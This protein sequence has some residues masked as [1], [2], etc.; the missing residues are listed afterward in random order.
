E[1]FRSALMKPVRLGR[2][3]ST[4]E[5]PV[6]ETSAIPRIRQ[7]PAR[8]RVC[9]AP[10][11]T[12]DQLYAAILGCAR[13]HR[14]PGQVTAL[15]RPRGGFESRGGHR[16]V[17]GRLGGCRRSCGVPARAPARGR[18][19]VRRAARTL[20]G[21]SRAGGDGLVREAASL[22]RTRAARWSAEL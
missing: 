16:G 5:I 21:G 11:A 20:A 8:I 17:G 3:W 4:T 22:G 19:T 2:P 7:G 9:P 14:L 6:C 15:S 13:P 1:I 18:G 10:T 12:C